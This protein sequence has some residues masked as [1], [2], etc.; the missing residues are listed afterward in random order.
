MTEL[1]NEK[2]VPCESDIPAMKEETIQEMK[3]EVPEW[4]V[5]KVDDIPHLKRSFKFDNFAEALEFTNMIG[6][7]AE[8]QGHHPVIELTWGRVTVEWWTHNINGLHKN[9]FVMAAKSSK[10]YHEFQEA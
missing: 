7:I 2:C 1:I 8:E 3:K 9:D 5:V 10:A 6:E 4:E